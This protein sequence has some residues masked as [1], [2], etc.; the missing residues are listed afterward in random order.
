MIGAY[1][2]LVKDVFV[3]ALSAI[4]VLYA[5]AFRWEEKICG[6]L[7]LVAI[8]PITVLA[9]FVHVITLVSIA[10]YDAPE[11]L[12][13]V[14]WLLS[15]CFCLA[16]LGG[17][18]CFPKDNCAMVKIALD[19]GVQLRIM[20]SGLAVNDNR[21][22]GWRGKIVG[23]AS[24]SLRGETAPCSVSPSNPTPTICARH[25]RSRW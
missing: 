10:S 21:E 23:A 17:S 18:S 13:G 9:N 1:Q 25:H 16:V 19:H 2:L 5:Y 20:E 6:L 3:F 22:R 12:G 11:L 7:V 15:F 8:V 24:G 4:A 14:S